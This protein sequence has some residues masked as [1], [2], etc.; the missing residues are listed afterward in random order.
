MELTSKMLSNAKVKRANIE[1]I[2]IAI[3]QKKEKLKSYNHN[4]GDTLPKREFF[5]NLLKDAKLIAK[6][7]LIKSQ[8]EMDSEEKAKL[9]EYVD[10]FT[11]AN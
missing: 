1:D 9:L 7:V 6:E 5:G 4:Y 10:S 11:V 3:T 8:S 2:Q